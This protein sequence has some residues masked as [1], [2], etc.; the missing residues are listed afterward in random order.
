MFGRVSKNNGESTYATFNAKSG[1]FVINHAQPDSAGLFRKHIA[2]GSGRVSYKEEHEAIQDVIVR[3]VMISQEPNY[4]DKS[5]M[6]NKIKISVRDQNGKDALVTFSMGQFAVKVLGLL[7]A[8]DLSKPL[9]LIGGSFAVGSEKTDL[10]TGAKTIREKAEPFL[11][12]TQNGEKLKASFSADPEFRIPKVEKIEVKNGAGAV[13]Q[14]VNDP[15][16]RDAFT[17]ELAAE[18]KAKVESASSKQ[19]NIAPAPVK[20][21]VA[22]PSDDDAGESSL[23]VND[24]V[25]DGGAA[26]EEAFN[27]AQRA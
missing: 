5:I 8:A 9:S 6:D 12:G 19:P 13:L 21:A 22:G 11:Y 4:D 14:V 18:V 2:E 10:A 27:S 23:S 1:L 24:I 3:R 20:A 25:G 15:S 26:D 16:K 17:L 7:R